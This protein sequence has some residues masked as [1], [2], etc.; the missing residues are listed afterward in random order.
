VIHFRTRAS[1]K[2]SVGQTRSH[3]ICG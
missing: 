3:N 1:S 2:T